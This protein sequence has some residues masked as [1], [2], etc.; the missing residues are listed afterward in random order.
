MKY[1]YM[2]WINLLNDSINLLIY[3]R[4]IYFINRIKVGSKLDL[5]KKLIFLW[6]IF[7]FDPSIFVQL[8]NYCCLPKEI[9]KR[10]GK[11]RLVNKDKNT[12][13]QLTAS[14]RYFWT[15]NNFF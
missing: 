15:E 9:L 3:R 4:F 8:D 5:K 12:N 11:Q 2:F 6:N 1:S 14:R 10:A 13:T 7:G